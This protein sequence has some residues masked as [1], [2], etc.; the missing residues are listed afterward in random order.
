MDNH[1]FRL[2]RRA[3]LPWLIA[4]AAVIAFT[5]FTIVYLLKV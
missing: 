1:D 3:R 2:R 4:G 5:Y